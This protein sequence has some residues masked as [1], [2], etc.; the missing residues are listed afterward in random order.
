MSWRLFTQPAT[1]FREHK[2]YVLTGRIVEIHY[3]FMPTTNN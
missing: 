3:K 2:I 1:E